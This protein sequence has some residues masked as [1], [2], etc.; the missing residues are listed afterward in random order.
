MISPQG[1]QVR[2]QVKN[3]VGPMFRAMLSAP[4]ETRQTQFEA[5]MSRTALPPDVEIE[6]VEAGGVSCEWVRIA[7]RA[8]ELSPRVIL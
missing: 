2:D 1:E 6:E 4:L 3:V 7:G 5:L 8:Q